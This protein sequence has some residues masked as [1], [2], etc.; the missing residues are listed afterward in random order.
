MVTSQQNGDQRNLCF[1][2]VHFVTIVFLHIF[3]VKLVLSSK[4]VGEILLTTN[5]TF[6]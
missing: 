4:D 3:K 5:V 6:S 1:Y 2:L